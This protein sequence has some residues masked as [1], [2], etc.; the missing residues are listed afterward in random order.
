MLKVYFQPSCSY[1]VTQTLRGPIPQMELDDPLLGDAVLKEGFNARA[2]L[3]VHAFLNRPL[4][5]A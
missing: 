1:V 4:W 2:I 3:V 5:L